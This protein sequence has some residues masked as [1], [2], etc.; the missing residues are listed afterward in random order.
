[1]GSIRTGQ[2]QRT[3]PRMRSTDLIYISEPHPKAQV[4][5]PG[6]GHAWDWT[7]LTYRSE[8]GDMGSIPVIPQ[9]MKRAFFA[10]P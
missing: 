5:M 7:R 8:L 4:G 6:F 9:R 2:R 1:M 3:A 10:L